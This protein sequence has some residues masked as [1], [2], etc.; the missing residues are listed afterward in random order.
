MTISID[1]SPDTEQKLR[2]LANE[3]GQAP[4]DYIR[5][6]IERDIRAHMDMDG[7]DADEPEDVNAL[8]RAIAALTN[9]TPEQ[10]A[11][12]QARIIATYQPRNPPAPGTSGMERVYGQ[13]PGDETDEE[14]NRALEELS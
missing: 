10:I 7:I 1:L 13:W 4:S 2:T 8:D 9:R 3:F 12:I 11:A 6:L 5:S 14:I